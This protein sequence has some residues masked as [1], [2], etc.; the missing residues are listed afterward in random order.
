MLLVDNIL[1]IFAQNKIYGFDVSDLKNPKKEWTVSLEDN[2]QY[3]QARLSDGK[4]YLVTRRNVNYSR[5]CPI[6][7]FVVNDINTTEIR[8]GDIYHPSVITPADVTYTIAT[9]NPETGSMNTGIS[10]VG[11]Y[12]A[13]VY[14]SQKGLYVAYSH[15]KSIFDF[16][17]GFLI[18]N[19]DIIPAHII[20]RLEKLQTYDLSDNAKM[21]EMGIIM[22]EVQQFLDGDEKLKMENEMENRM[23]SYV[24]AHKR[25][26]E[27]TSIVK[28]DIESFKVQDIG[29]VP[30]HLLNQFSL[31]EYEENLRVAITIG[32][33]N[34][35]RW[36]YGIDMEEENDVYVLDEKMKTIG[37]VT[38]LGKDEKIYSVRFIGDRG[39]LVTFKQIDPFFVLDLSDPRNPQVTGE[40][41]IPGFSSYLHPISDNIILGIGREG[42][43]VKMSL[44]DVSDPKNPTEVAKY[45]LNEYWSEIQNTHHAFLQDSKHEV[46]FMPGDQGG[47]V[48]SYKNNEL[49]MV[50][51][52]S[53]LRARRAV[54]L[55][56]YLYIIGD[57][58][59]VIL[60]ETDWQRVNELN[61]SE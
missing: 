46:F 25:D 37:K 52:V 28:I 29:I 18:E 60:N 50:K 30:G 6:R 39:Y 8:C 56:D 24:D 7:P 43:K 45:M 3:L 20:T 26:L 19:K 48:F 4:I 35:F 15:N 34:Q 1:A 42:S 41:K 47:F 22:N 10:F 23:D 51:A 5:P 38:G 57:N 49:K 21:T 16:F 59:I 32:G 54:Y 9:I 53:G 17:A 2:M 12:N 11:S 61:L 31:D 27:K 13:T 14:M 58:K 44:F 33:R 36:Q 55:D 40:L